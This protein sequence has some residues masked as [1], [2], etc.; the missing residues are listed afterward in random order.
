[1]ATTTIAR[2]W[3][4][5]DCAAG[6]ITSGTCAT[7]GTTNFPVSFGKEFANIPVVVATVYQKGTLE[8]FLHVNRV[9]NV[10]K[11]GCTIQVYN[12]A[13]SNRDLDSDRCIAWVAVDS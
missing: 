6:Q 13:S 9:L 12:N 7:L 10:T 1:M 3:S 8:N 11:T 4:G 5:G 2:P